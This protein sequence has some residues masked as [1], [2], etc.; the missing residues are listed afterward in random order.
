[1]EKWLE[2]EENF[3]MWYD[4]IFVKIRRVLMIK[5]VGKVW[6]ELSFDEDFVKK[7]FEKIGC[8]M[9]VDGEDDEKIRL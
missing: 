7:F 3:E 1:M 2:K 8:L 6:R 4:G 5:W 9:I